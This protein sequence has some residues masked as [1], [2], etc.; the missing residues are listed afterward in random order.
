[1]GFKFAASLT[2]EFADG[3]RIE[4][5]VTGRNLDRKWLATFQSQM[6]LDSYGPSRSSGLSRTGQSTAE[7]FKAK[8]SEHCLDCAKETCD[9]FS[10]DGRY[11]SREQMATLMGM[12]A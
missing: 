5:T 9:L 2:G 6:L 11:I 12:Q 3:E 7:E 1:L 8:W 10:R 4:W